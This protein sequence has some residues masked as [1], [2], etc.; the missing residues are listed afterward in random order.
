MNPLGFI[1]TSCTNPPVTL[2]HIRE[3]G[4]RLLWRTVM[5]NKILAMS[6][7]ASK[8]CRLPQFSGIKCYFIN[9]RGPGSSVGIATELRVGRSGDRIL[10]GERFSAP[11]QTGPGAHP[12]S[13]TT[14]TESFP[15]VKSGRGVT[16]TPHPLLVP[17]SWKSRAILLL[18]LWAVRAAQSLSACTRVHFTLPFTYRQTKR[19]RSCVFGFYFS[20][21]RVSASPNRQ[22]SCLVH[23]NSKRR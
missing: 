3:E 14:G 18:P 6:T 10:V 9:R 8:H 1:E 13:C 15:G 21:L 19:H 12:A 7:F 11:V 2:S 5:Y 16:L 22:L 4:K 17:W 20:Q 23:Q